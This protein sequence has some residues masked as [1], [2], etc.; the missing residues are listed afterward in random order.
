MYIH[1]L[2]R[3]LLSRALFNVCKRQSV[4]RACIRVI[5]VFHT[6]HKIREKEILKTIKADVDMMILASE[7]EY[8]FIVVYILRICRA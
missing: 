4:I 3:P 8:T 2:F 6:R 5:A 1:A 7:R